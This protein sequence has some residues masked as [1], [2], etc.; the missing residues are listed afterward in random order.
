MDRPKSRLAPVLVVAFI[1]CAMLAAYV[2]SYLFSGYAWL[3]PGIQHRGFYRE[4]QLTL[5]RPLGQIESRL[6]GNS[7]VLVQL[8]R[9]G[10]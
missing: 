3:E 10:A 1:L 4:W 9:Y 7:V 2:G 6:T 8:T 5:Y